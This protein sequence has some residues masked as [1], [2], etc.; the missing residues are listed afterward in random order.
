MSLNSFLTRLI[1]LCVSPLLLLAAYLAIT[2]VRATQAE[3]DLE[4]ANLAKNVATAID[5][6]LAARIGALRILAMSPLAD[7]PSHWNELYQEAQ[8]FR[9]SFG[10]NII[11][12]D[13]EMRMLFNTRV[14]FG[15]SLPMLQRPPGH[16][17]A[18]TALE[19]GKP[20]IGDS[21]LGPITKEPMIAIAVPGLRDGKVAFLVLTAVEARHFQNRLEQVALPSGWSLALLDGNGEAIARRAPPGLNAATDVDATGRW[22]VKSAASPWSVVLEIPRDIRRAP[23]VAA[24]ATLAMALV[25]ATL[26]GVLGGMLASRRLGTSVAS[27]SEIPARGAPPPDITEIAAL[28]GLLDESAEKRVAAEA[29]EQEG[30]Q[31]FRATFEQA[32]VGIAVVAPDGRWLR[33]NQKL[34]D[35]VGYGH[36]EL[37]TKTF[38]D[39]THP[40]DLDADLSFVRQMLAGEIETYSTEKRYL[41]KR[42]AIV[43]INLTVAL[44]RKPDATPDYFISV[45]EDI[46]SRKRAE[47]TQRES[48]AEL[49]QAEE[50]VRRLNANLELRVLERTAELTAANKELD[51]FAYAVSHDLRAPLR[52]IDG[53]ATV[54]EEDYAALLDDEG[55][56]ALRRVRGATQRMGDLIDNLLKLS[57]LVRSDMNVESVDLSALAR[58]IAGE[59]KESEPGRNVTFEIPPNLEGRGDR[60]LLAVLLDNLL[61]NAWKFTRKHA[62]ARIELGVTEHNGEAA[63]FVRDDGAGFDIAQAANLFT[64]FQRLHSVSDFP[65]TGIGLAT[66]RRI[67]QRH[68][69]CVWAEAA[70]DKGA[71]IYFTLSA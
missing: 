18:P 60:R 31:R 14:P 41:H 40:D 26:I 9:Q 8:G 44:V 36:D 32:A 13:M 49:K 29:A 23:L 70:I 67:V 64:P 63:Y 34:C 24:A 22:V 6:D 3:T 1:W 30:E 5:Q 42:G 69:G 28:R 61:G 50:E 21:F 57:R 62:S 11:V 47:T 68:G 39:I 33:V 38:Q 17:A 4:A 15:T 7:R 65:G 53:F 71:A 25:G 46:Q 51:S 48:E 27:L 52:S 20:A 16:A 12:A 54:L 55:K 19:T 66:V 56:D 2:S 35:I 10:S 58:S 59:L 37:L 43:W 45:I